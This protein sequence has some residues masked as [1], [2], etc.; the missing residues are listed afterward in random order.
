M[1]NLFEFSFQNQQY[2]FKNFLHICISQRYQASG[3]KSGRPGLRNRRDRGSGFKRCA[4]SRTDCQRFATGFEYGN[5]NLFELP[6]TYQRYA[7]KKVRNV[8]HVR[9][10]FANFTRK[11]SRVIF[12]F[13]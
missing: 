9:Q 11:L 1:K 4:K 8:N 10:I 12:E 3:E 2:F 7:T 5:K 13:A 6:R